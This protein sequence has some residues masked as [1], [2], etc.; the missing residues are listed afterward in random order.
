MSILAIAA[1]AIAGVLAVTSVMVQSDAKA[2]G[3]SADSFNDVDSY[4]VVVNKR[5]PL[6]ADFSPE[7]LE[8]VAVPFEGDEPRLR[9]QVAHAVESLFAAFTAE[10]GLEMRSNSAYRSRTAQQ[11]EYA[12]FAQSTGDAAV[13]ET[14]ARPGYSEHQTGLAIDIGAVDSGCDARACFAETKQSHWLATNAWR[15]GFILRYPKGQKS[16]TGYAYEPWHIRYV[17]RG[18]AKKIHGHYSSLEAYFDLDPAP[19]Y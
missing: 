5:R 4:S 1:A 3:P 13:D 2:T 19:T 12:A 17:G 11:A 9:S 10:T 18:L 7:D 6:P 16:V 15:F 8:P 14:T